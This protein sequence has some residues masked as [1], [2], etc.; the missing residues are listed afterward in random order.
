MEEQKYREHRNTLGCGKIM[1]IL[2]SVLM[3]LIN[4]LVVTF[5]IILTTKLIVGMD[6]AFVRALIASLIGG[7]V[8]GILYWLF[9]M[10]LSSY[11]WIAGIIIFISYLIIIRFYFGSGNIGALIVA[12]LACVVYLVFSWFF[13]AIVGPLLRGGPAELVRECGLEMEDGF[14][15]ECHLCYAARK[16]LRTRFPELL[17]PGCVYGVKAGGISWSGK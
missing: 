4:W 9:A 12:V 7:I 14:V 5:I 13:G 6:T 2:A 3:F 15:D 11:W 16:S 10:Y 1:Q 17:G 8:T